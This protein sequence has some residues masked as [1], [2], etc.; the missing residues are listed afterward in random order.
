MKIVILRVHLPSS[1][2]PAELKLTSVNQFSPNV[3]NLTCF[4]LGGGREG[5]GYS[6]KYITLNVSGTNLIRQE[7]ANCLLFDLI[8][9]IAN[10]HICLLCKVYEANGSSWSN[11]C[12]LTRIVE[13]A[14]A[15]H[16]HTIKSSE[17]CT[18]NLLL[19]W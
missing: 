11:Y 16:R 3:S 18:D 7:R 12:C 13:Q 2:H 14:V 5:E 10:T 1:C 6:V 15:C 17:L 9:L 8:P 19:F 4:I